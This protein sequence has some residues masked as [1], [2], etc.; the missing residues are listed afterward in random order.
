MLREKTTWLGISGLVSV[1]A[2][3]FTGELTWFQAIPSFLMAAASA[4]AA[5]RVSR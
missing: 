3:V 2:G 1:L 5:D 4:F